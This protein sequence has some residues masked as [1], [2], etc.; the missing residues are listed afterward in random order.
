LVR[1]SKAAASMS[2]PQSNWIWKV[3][4][5]ASERERSSSMPASVESASSTGRVMSCSTSSGVEPG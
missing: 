2:R 5:S 1:T 3:A 4:C